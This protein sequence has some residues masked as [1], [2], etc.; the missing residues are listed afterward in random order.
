MWSG[1]VTSHCVCD[2][3]TGQRLL[4]SADVDAVSFSMQSWVGL[5][6]FLHWTQYGC[7]LLWRQCLQG[8]SMVWYFFLGAT[9]GQMV[10]KHRHN[11]FLR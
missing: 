5:W 9:W 7:Y 11:P 2:L 8:L 3:V 4:I 6:M 1:Q 10:V